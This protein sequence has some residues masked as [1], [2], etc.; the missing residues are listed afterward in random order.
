MQ[1]CEKKNG[2]GRVY[3]CKVLEREVKNYQKLIK[4]NRA[5]GELDH[6]DDSV[7]NLKNFFVI[8]NF[9]LA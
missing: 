2:N 9:Y 6:P 1:T 4:D 3:P 7:I 8:I 5:L